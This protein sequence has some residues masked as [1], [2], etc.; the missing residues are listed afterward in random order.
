[1]FEPSLNSKYF[2]R[3]QHRQ[4][5]NSGLF[6]DAEA[7]INWISRILL[8]LFFTP[9]VAVTSLFAKSTIVII[10]NI[11]LSIGYVIN[12]FYRSYSGVISYPELLLNVVCISIAIFFASALTGITLFPVATFA[13]VLFSLNII[14]TAVNSFFMI[15]NLIIPALTRLLESVC[16]KIGLEINTKLFQRPPLTIDKDR[17]IIDRLFKKHYGFDTFDERFKS[18]DNDIERYLKPFNN[19]LHTLTDYLNKYHHQAFGNVVNQQQITL[20]EKLINELVCDGETSNVFK[21]LDKKIDFK[22]TKLQLLRTVKENVSIAIEDKSILKFNE[23]LFKYYRNIPGA[24]N[25]AEKISLGT[26]ALSLI[27]KEIKRQENKREN[28]L[29]CKPL[30]TA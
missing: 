9:V 15:K 2:K 5:L 11:S 16:A 4:I 7:S 26:E 1:M 29:K 14:A 19:I 21:F 23:M 10:A 13:G 18:N 30:K 3:N 12:L 8:A 25:S 22:A 24:D 28:L 27:G 6:G 17:E 20:I